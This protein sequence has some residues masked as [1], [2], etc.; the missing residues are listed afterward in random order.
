MQK[1]AIYNDLVNRCEWGEPEP[2]RKQQLWNMIS[3]PFNEDP[4]QV[5]FWK[6]DAFCQFSSQSDLMEPYLD[7]YYERAPMFVN[8]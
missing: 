3:D 7:K 6:E 2:Q 1:G 4:L 5:Y 8:F